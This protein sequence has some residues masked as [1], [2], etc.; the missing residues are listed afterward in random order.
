MFNLLMGL[1][2]AFFIVC[3]CELCTEKLSA[4]RNRV[5]LR[6][7]SAFSYIQYNFFCNH[8]VLILLNR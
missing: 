8:I 1:A 3:E 5:S 2:K 7:D 4:Q 6:D